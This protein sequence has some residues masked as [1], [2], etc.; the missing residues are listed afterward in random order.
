MSSNEAIIKPSHFLS[1]CIQLARGLDYLSKKRFVHRDI[2]TRNCLVD[3]QFVC[4]ISDFGLSRDVYGSGYYGLGGK[5]SLLPV[6]W[7]S[8]ESLLY[9]RVTVKSDV[10]SY[11]VLM[12]EVFTFAT[13]PYF[14]ASN[15]EAID[16]IQQLVLL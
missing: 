14:G 16:N 4:K 12:W 1:I 15:Q 13:Q 7:M 3:S 2:A 9:G 8:S 5:S 6:R 11:G 10:C